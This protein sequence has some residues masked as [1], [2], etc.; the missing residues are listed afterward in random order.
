MPRVGG[1]VLGEEG[2]SSWSSSI[3]ASN[4]K[5]GYVSLSFLPCQHY[6]FFFLR[7]RPPGGLGLTATS[8]LFLRIIH[9]KLNF[10]ASMKHSGMHVRLIFT[11]VPTRNKWHTQIN[12]F[13]R[14]FIYIG[15]NYKDVGN[16]RRQ[17]GIVQAHRT[18]SRP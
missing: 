13:Q 2:S 4:C 18:S 15:T 17:Q 9:K 11:R 10:S 8:I 12:V 7:E 3:G 14:E 1:G 6:C 16:V 5:D